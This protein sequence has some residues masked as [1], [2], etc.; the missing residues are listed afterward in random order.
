MVSS[1]LT[2]EINSNQTLELISNPKELPD[3]S[4][5]SEE[6]CALNFTIRRQTRKKYPGAC[7]LEFQNTMDIVLKCLLNWDSDKKERSGT[8]IVGDLDGWAQAGEEQGRGSLHAH[9]Q[10]FTEQLSTK[11]RFELFH[12]DELIHDT[13]R[14]EL[15]DYID[16]MICASYGTKLQIT[17]AC[18]KPQKSTSKHEIHDKKAKEMS[19]PG[20]AFYPRHPQIFRDARHKMI[21]NRIEGDLITCGKCSGFVRSSDIPNKFYKD[22]SSKRRVSHCFFLLPIHL[23]PFIFKC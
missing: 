3:V 5:L 11:I 1:D 20:D 4:K 23:F 12:R 13:A 7:S 22:Q 9:W 6:E 21:C 14:K 10:L 16:N 18:N 17:H 8:G 15:A 2:D 19:S